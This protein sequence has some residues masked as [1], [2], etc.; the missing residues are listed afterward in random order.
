M[1][2]QAMSINRFIIILCT[3]LLAGCSEEPATEKTDTKKTHVWQGQV[4][5]L[6]EAK[7]VGQ[8]VNEMQLQK[9][10]RMHNME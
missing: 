8:E 3:L 5:M 4:D 10:E 9:E 1:S 6:N 2:E 7:S